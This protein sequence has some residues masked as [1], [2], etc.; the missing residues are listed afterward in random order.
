MRLVITKL[1][2]LTKIAT[3]ALAM[4]TL[5]TITSTKAQAQVN[6]P[7]PGQ[8]EEPTAEWVRLTPEE[9]ICRWRAIAVEHRELYGIPASITMGQA[10]LESG[11]G[12]GYLARVANNHFCIKCKSSWTGRTVS[13]TDDAPDECFRAY[14][15]GEE[16]FRDHADFL[17]TGQ[18]YDFLFAYADDDY[19]SWARGLKQAGYATASDYAE[20]LISVIE[21]YNL[22][23]LDQENGIELYDAYLAERL[24][25]IPTP[26]PEP[27]V[28]TEPTD[29]ATTSGQA[30]GTEAGTAYGGNNIDPNNFRVTINAHNGYNIYRTNGSLYVVAREGDSYESIGRTFEVAARSLRKFNDVENDTQPAAGDVVYIERKAARWAGDNMLHTVVEGETLYG[31][32]QL[33]GIRLVQLSKINRMRPTEHLVAGQTIRIK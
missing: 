6:E 7:E 10:V 26:A 21:R 2:C 27:T 12:N 14:D 4:A 33:Y 18:R 23:L 3:T 5:F 1:Y 24:G 9:Y 17:S 31:L 11:F 25:Q 22:Q 29:I 32:S 13:H 30:Q 15:S 16:S 28:E 19:E 8:G 20:R